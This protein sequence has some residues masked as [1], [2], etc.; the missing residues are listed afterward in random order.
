M[1]TL[2]TDNNTKTAEELDV[3]ATV[4]AGKKPRL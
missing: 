1:S 4:L 3:E 2:I